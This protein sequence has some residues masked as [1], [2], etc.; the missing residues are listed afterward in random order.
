MINTFV[1]LSALA[2]RNPFWP[3]DYHGQYEAISP[4]PRVQVK[5]TAVAAGETENAETAAL[6]AALAAE[7][8]TTEILPRHWAEARKTL[9]TTGTTQITDSYGNIRQC[10]IINGGAYGNGDLISTNHKGRR[11]T[12]RVV[13]LTDH[14]T[15]KLKKVRAKELDEEDKEEKAK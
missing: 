7:N 14:S 3:V 9:K 13:G 5:Q 11:F 12:W 6:A 2:V 10:V 1:L 15:L 4:E 8:D